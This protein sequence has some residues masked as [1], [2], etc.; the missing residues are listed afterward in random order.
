MGKTLPYFTGFASLNEFLCNLL[1]TPP[2]ALRVQTP[3]VWGTLYLLRSRLI[4]PIW[5]SLLKSGLLYWWCLLGNNGQSPVS[6]G[7][8]LTSERSTQF[9]NHQTPNELYIN[10]RHYKHKQC[11]E[12]VILSIIHV[13]LARLLKYRYAAIHGGCPKPFFSFI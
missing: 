1:H 7:T 8:V 2:V 13:N 5:V 3:E 6:L 11:K 12:Q 9:S 4:L 10:T